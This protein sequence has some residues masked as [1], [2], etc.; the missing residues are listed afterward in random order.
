MRVPMQ[1]DEGSISRMPPLC[2]QPA[3]AIVLLV[4]VFFAVVRY[5]LRDM[6]LE[7]DEGEYAYSGQLML[8]EIPPYK[9]AYNMKLP[10]I[11]AAYA[12]TMAAFGENAA[13]IHVGL[14]LTNAAAVI[15]LYL[16]AATFFGPWAGAVAACTYALLSTSTSVM[17]FEAHATNFVVPFALLS[18]WL[19]V[20]GLRIGRDS[21]L[22]ASGISAGVSIL[23]K[24][25]GIFF[26]GFCF[27]YLFWSDEQSLSP[28]R[29]PCLM[30]RALIY[31]FGVVL[32]Y[33]ATCATMYRAEVFRQ[34]WFWTVS[35]AGEY[36]KVGLRRAVR[37][38]VENFS[39]V[40]APAFAVW[41]IAAIGLSALWWSAAARKHFRF[42]AGLFAFSFLSL[43]PGAYFRPHYFILFLPV[44]AILAGIAVIAV[45]DKLHGHISR[46][47][48]LPLLIFLAGALLS[49]Y[50]QRAEYFRMT[51][52]QV[53][54][55]T[56]GTDNAFVPSM[57]IAEYLRDHSPKDSQIAVLGSE[58]EIYFY[59]QRH[60]AVSYIYMYSLIGHQRYSIPMREEML[61]Q[62]ETNR[63]EY[64]VYVDVWDSWGERNG[65]AQAAPFLAELD[66][67]RRENYQPLAVADIGEG[68]SQYPT[69]Y[70]WGD[71]T[72]TYTPRSAR[73]IYLLQRKSEAQSSPN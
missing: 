39:A 46:P 72:R 4:I 25:H 28:E 27:I 66:R 52:L 1:T 17:G 50:R 11:Y 15:L 36:S 31:S 55:S 20:L 40:A 69:A 19:M 37:A 35:Y 65:V 67:Y 24:Q 42:T 8:Q 33:A 21:F 30:R 3:A 5:R 71:V 68:S 16:L 54:E 34:F 18:I 44:I 32:P 6:P 26:A 10:G 49:V 22:F 14:I 51:A 9:L 47:L 62:L 13:G 7:R 48:R 57:R 2:R 61:H 63:P 23:M 41:I 56:Y 60:S 64:L 58:P 73:V 43:C 12:A 38:L 59:A 45:S 53:F 70:I 29:A